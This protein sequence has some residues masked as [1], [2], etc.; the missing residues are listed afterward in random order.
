MNAIEIRLKFLDYFERHGHKEIVGSSVVPVNDPSVLFT[1]AGMHP[2]VPYLLGETHPLGRRLVDYQ[3]CVRTD[4]I[5]EVG[6][7]IHITFFEMLGNWSLGDY[8]KEDAVRMSFDFLVNE[9]GLNPERIVVTVFEGDEDAPA[10]IETMK[11]WKSLG[12]KDDKIFKFG[13]KHNWWGPAGQTGPCGP[14]TE[15]FF[16]TLKPKCSEECSPACKCGKYWEVWNNVFMEYN[17]EKDGTFTIL[18]QKNVDTGMGLERI[19]AILEG[20]ESIYETE[21][22]NEIINKIISITRSE[23]TEIVNS[24]RIIADHVRAACF[25]ISD[26]VRPSNVEQGYILRRLIRRAI[27]HMR[28]IGIS[29]EE[30]MRLGYIA[31][32]SLE[33]IYP[34]LIGNDNI[35]IGCLKGEKNKFSKTIDNGERKIKKVIEYNKK[36]AVKII[37]AETVFQL[38][39]TF[40]FPPEITN[41]IAA[42]NGLTVDMERFKLLYRLHQEKSRIGAEKKFKGGLADNAI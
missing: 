34:E 32:H 4:D 38:Y 8:F 28:K 3:K 33:E 21:L 27:R 23:N 11:V 22:F 24:I 30:I 35:I 6:D 37:D 7:E 9:L 5:E 20:K 15:I 31:I 2:L 39:D 42:E 10:D 41:E 17:K 40:G 29:S 12:I 19:T 26:G 16:D 14:D 36:E 13:R 18:K 25:I 1:T